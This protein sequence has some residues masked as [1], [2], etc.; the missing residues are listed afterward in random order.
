[1]TP[2]ENID[3]LIRRF[4]KGQLSEK[5]FAELELLKQTDPN[6]QKQ[7]DDNRMLSILMNESKLIDIKN[8]AIKAHKTAIK[9]NEI[10]KRVLIA[11]GIAT[12]TLIVIATVWYANTK[13]QAPLKQT[14]T[15]E[16]AHLSETNNV[17]AKT[18]TLTPSPNT[19]DNP[20]GTIEHD[21]TVANHTS[22]VDSIPSLI[23]TSSA[24]TKVGETSKTGQKTNLLNTTTAIPRQDSTK[25]IDPCKKVTLQAEFSIQSTCK[26]EQAGSIALSRCSGGYKPYHFK[27][28]DIHN[29]PSHDFM[30][31]EAGSYKILITDAKAC[32]SWQEVIVPEKSCQSH[33]TINPFINE[34]WESPK[35]D[36]KG[37]LK[38][39][40]KKG[41]IYFSQ[42]LAPA[43]VLFWDGKSN[44]GDIKSGYYL[45]FIQ[46]EDNSMINGTVTIIE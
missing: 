30:H 1:M 22:K 21:K 16:K 20:Q 25:G 15:P 45:F 41:N 7:L 13:K 3:L 4:I 12:I 11:G 19:T 18:V 33:Y 2:Q 36:K 6:I 28:Y 29:N 44:N 40:D 9:R 17:T 8:I 32:N 24:D 23:G 26:G 34:T 43:E 31:L 27:V 38:I 35:M 46:Y 14:N 39:V 42:N 5:E 37:Y 10:I